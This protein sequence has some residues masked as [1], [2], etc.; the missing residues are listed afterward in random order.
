MNGKLIIGTIV[1]LLATTILE[2]TLN[3]TQV[4]ATPSIIRVPQDY[5]TIQQAINAAVDGDTILVAAGTYYENFVLNKTVS[6]VGEQRE[7]TVIDGNGTGIVDGSGA[8]AVVWVTATGVSVSNFTIRNSKS[9]IGYGGIVLKGASN[10]RILNNIIAENTYGIWVYKSTSN[11]TISGNNITRNGNGIYLY[12]LQISHNTI[13][14]NNFSQNVDG[15]YSDLSWENTIIGNSFSDHIWAIT[16]DRSGGNTLK[17][18]NMT[19]EYWQ[20]GVVADPNWGGQFSHFIQDIDTSNLINGEPVYY[21]INQKDLTVDP[22]N[23]PNIGYLALINSTNVTVRNLNLTKYT[24]QGLL[25]AFTDNSLVEN[26]E[27]QGV[28]WIGGIHLV[29]SNYNTFARNNVSENRVDIHLDESSYNTFFHNVLGGAMDVSSGSFSNTWDN[30]YPSGGNY[31]SDYA[32]EDIYSGPYQN[33][34]GSDGIGDTPYSGDH[35]PLMNSWPVRDVAVVS[36]VPSEVVV[37]EGDMLSVNVSIINQGDFTES[38]NLIVYANT[39]II[40]TQSIIDL[41]IRNLTE[42]TFTWNTTGFPH[43]NYTISA[44]AT[45][46]PNETDTEDNNFVDDQVTVNPPVRDVAIISVSASPTIVGQGKNVTVN[47]DVVNQGTLWET[48]SVTIYAN[49]TIIWFES[50]SLAAGGSI[51]ITFNWNTTSFAFGNYTIKAVASTVPDETD[52]EDNT[53]IN[54]IVTVVP[55]YTLTITT[56]IG[57]TTS[58]SPGT[59]TYLSSTVVSVTATPSSGY[60]FL[61]WELDGDTNT[62]NPISITM[63]TDHALHAVFVYDVT[64]RA[65]CYTEGVYVSV[66]ITMDGTPTGYN[67]SHTFTGLTGTHTFTVPNTDANDHPFYRWIPGSPSTTITVSSGGTCR[68]FYGTPSPPPPVGGI[69]VPIDKLGLLVPYIG[70]ASTVIVATVASAIYVKCVK[71]RKEKQ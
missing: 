7:T 36:V 44:Y 16:L 29:Q 63:D 11:V 35:Y 21:L 28:S 2:F 18:N 23:F 20:F 43:G 40:G 61:R 54:G 42:L 31:W 26:T 58:P 34:T 67:T 49:T 17:N 64:I 47:V 65:Y 60:Y 70:L 55:I 53:Y 24:Q 71:R 15:I 46:V 57:G 9:E 8:G 5:P 22:A 45:T 56:T 1:L 37:E 62:T 50:V 52:T 33:E 66:N 32:G 59:Y 39:T 12:F 19:G 27:V 69:A 25:F 38:F 6:L 41:S 10:S 30:G 51:P 68:A 14:G 3:T 48:F 13:A 4:G